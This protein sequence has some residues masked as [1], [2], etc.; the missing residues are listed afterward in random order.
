[1]IGRKIRSFVTF[2]VEK[3]LKKQ[4]EG[5]NFND[6]FYI[7][8]EMRLSGVAEQEY[9]IVYGKSQISKYFRPLQTPLNYP[10]LLTYLRLRPDQNAQSIAAPAQPTS[11]YPPRSLF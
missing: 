7:L 2:K 5:L 11:A 4:S 10:H 1:M 8:L 3:P 9:T 6:K